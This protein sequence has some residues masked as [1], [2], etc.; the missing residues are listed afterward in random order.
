[1][2]EVE[3][4]NSDNWV[5]ED[6]IKSLE[7]AVGRILT[8]VDGFNA[9]YNRE[10]GL[11]VVDLKHRPEAQGTRFRQLYVKR[12]NGVINV[13]LIESFKSAHGGNV[14]RDNKGSFDVAVGE[15]E[16]RK[17]EERFFGYN[18]N[19]SLSGAKR[20]VDELEETMR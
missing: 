2:S 14:Q 5:N 9:K 19:K 8:L 4:E 18:T 20:L 10:Q 13:S 15:P 3:I 1:M 17:L 6:D 12:E 11:S 16:Y 7:E